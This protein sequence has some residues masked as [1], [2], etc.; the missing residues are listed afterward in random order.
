MT[1][2][3]CCLW[4]IIRRLAVLAGIVA[5]T[6]IA[7][8]WAWS[9]TT[10]TK[11]WH[12]W[13]CAH[14]PIL[15]ETHASSSP[16]AGGP[17]TPKETAMPAYRVTFDRIGRNHDVPP[18]ELSADGDGSELADRVYDV[19][20]RPHLGSREVEVYVNLEEMRGL[21]VV[22]GLRPGGSFTLDLLPQNDP[23]TGDEAAMSGGR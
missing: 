19:V 7:I 2:H 14:A 6:I 18:I 16:P 4:G 5:V 15:C 12:T 1:G 23:L 22:G 8:R 3:G 20:A 10:P 17:P 13:T 21:I 11:T 9:T